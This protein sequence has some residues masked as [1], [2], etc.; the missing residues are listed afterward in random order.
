VKDISSLR[1]QRGNPEVI[2]WLHLYLFG[3]EKLLLH[4]I[5][6][7]VS[8]RFTHANLVKCKEYSF[9]GLPR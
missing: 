2:I 5:N 4:Q 6:K 9:F 1:A 7:F 3:K 8:A